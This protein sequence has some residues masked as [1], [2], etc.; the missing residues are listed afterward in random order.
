MTDNTISVL[1]DRLARAWSLIVLCEFDG[2]LADCVAADPSSARPAA[3]AIEAMAELGS[4]VRTSTG[5]LS[6]RSSPS[7]KQICLP[8][9]GP[10]AA[11]SIDFVGSG[12]TEHTPLARAGLSASDERVRWLLCQGAL[13]IAG[14]Y[15]GA[16]VE[17]NRFGIAL[18]LRQLPTVDVQQ[19]IESMQALM[20]RMPRPVHWQVRNLVMEVSV[21]PL[22]HDRAIEVL[23]QPL[24]S[25][26]LYAGSDPRAH[27]ALEPADA[28]VVVGAAAVPGAVWLKSPRDL[29]RLLASLARARHEAVGSAIDATG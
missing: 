4:C 18:Y 28:G 23:R 22:G 21:V 3:G 20:A 25:T 14:T 8:G 10:A 24:T 17:E 7:L 16:I 1:V 29:V 12:G 9:G 6:H 27:A 2:T 13:W 19:L 26:V 5:V 15:P 11:A